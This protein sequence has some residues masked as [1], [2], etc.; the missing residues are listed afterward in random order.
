MYLLRFILPC[1]LG[2]NEESEC[3]YPEIGYECD[4]DCS[5]GYAPLT[6]NWT[7]ADETTSFTITSQ[8][9]GE[10]FSYTVDNWYGSETQCWSTDLEQDCFTVSINGPESVQWDLYTYYSSEPLLSGSNEDF[11]FGPEVTCQDVWI[12]MHVTMI[13]M[14]IMMMVLVNTL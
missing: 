9:L 11:L 5:Y 10:L 3:I 1:N 8:N 2:C 4:G 6:L 14:L 12:K 13:L 7:N